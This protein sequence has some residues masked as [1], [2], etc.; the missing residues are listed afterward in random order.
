MIEKLNIQQ[1]NDIVIQ[2]KTECLVV[3][4]ATWCGPSESLLQ[5]IDTVSYELEGMNI[6][7]VDIDECNELIDKYS[8]EAVPMT[9]MFKNG[10]AVESIL[11]VIGQEKL[12]DEI[13]EMIN[14]N[15]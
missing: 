4:T 6:Y 12:I 7:N 1:F 15:N 3:F 13:K 5:M 9:T 11:G 2:D 8:M 14:Q 10:E